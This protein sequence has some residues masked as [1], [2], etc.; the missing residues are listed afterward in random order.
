MGQTGWAWVYD[1]QSGGQRIPPEVQEQV[2]E[3]VMKHAA[4]IV[5]GKEGWLRIRF[6][7]AFCYLDAQMPDESMLTHLCRLRYL[8]QPDR[9]SL[10][11]FTYSHE[12]YEPCVFTT[13]TWEGTPEQALAI[14]A[15]YLA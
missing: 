10:A 15:T 2:R 6:Q 5:P 4:Q 11:F 9:W 13:G 12:R 3:R 14:G 7:G 1:P 8:G